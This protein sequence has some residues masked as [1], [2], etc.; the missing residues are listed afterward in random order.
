MAEP[1]LYRASWFQFENTIGDTRPLSETSSPTTTI[2]AP[3]DLT[4]AAG[5]YIL[6]ELSADSTEHPVWRRSIRTYFRM[7]ADGWK[8][9]GLER[10]PDG[11]P[12]AAPLRAANERQR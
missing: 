8:L 3:G 11:P 1:E 9:V 5:S 4:T 12:A 2:D 7:E 6:V 10:M